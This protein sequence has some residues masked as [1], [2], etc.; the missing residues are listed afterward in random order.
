M[1]D[2]VILSKENTE[3]TFKL[4]DLHNRYHKLNETYKQTEK[5]KRKRKREER[6]ISLF[7]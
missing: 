6:K 5:E 3:L 1:F 4:Q 7:L 2:A